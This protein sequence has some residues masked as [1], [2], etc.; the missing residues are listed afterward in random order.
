MK[1]NRRNF[2]ALTSMGLAG[3]GLATMLPDIVH[4]GPARKGHP[5]RL[6]LSQFSL[7]S[8]FWTKQL[9]PL[10]FPAKIHEGHLKLK[11]S[12]IVPCFLQTRQR[13][14]HF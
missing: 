14:Q 3:A 4:A 12:I 2:L 5:Y 8:Q 6:A 10:D 9:D 13:T 1:H 11:D 7:A